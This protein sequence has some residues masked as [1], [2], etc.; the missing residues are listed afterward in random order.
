MNHTRVLSAAWSVCLLLAGSL[1]ADDIVIDTSLNIET[2][3]I[4]GSE[5]PGPYKHPASITQL[6]N[7]DLYVAYYG[8]R[9]NTV[10]TPRSMVRVASRVKQ[11]GR[12]R[13]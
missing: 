5:H 11:T 4:F 2:N 12:R 7:G 13:W 1:S 8:A 3:R 6:S 10:P 9:A